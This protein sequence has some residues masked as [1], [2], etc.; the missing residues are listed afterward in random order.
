MT[1]GGH[2]DDGGAGKPASA[3]K[4]PRT[5]PKDREK[6]AHQPPSAVNEPAKAGR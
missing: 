1:N 4:P 6:A 5:E 3:P 2:P